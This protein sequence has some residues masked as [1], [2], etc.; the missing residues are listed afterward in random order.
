MRGA[1]SLKLEDAW[2]LY[3]RL[4]NTSSCVDGEADSRALE[5]SWRQFFTQASPAS[6]VLDLA[7]GNG[8]VAG[9]AAS[10]SHARDLKLRIVGVD[11]AQISPAAIPEATFVSGVH[12][13]TLPFANQSVDT[14]VSQFGFEYGARER[15]AKEAVRVLK[16]GGQLR[17]VVHARAGAVH[18]AISAQ[19][20]R[21]EVVLEQ[22]GVLTTLLSAAEAEADAARRVDAALA[23]CW[24]RSQS[25]LAGA[26]DQDAATYYANGLTNLWRSRHRYAPTDVQRSIDDAQQRAAGILVRQRA[27]L[28]AA[29]SRAD[30]DT[31]AG[32][33]R[34][35]GLAMNEPLPINDND[36]QQIAWLIE[37]VKRD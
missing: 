8:F 12:M 4:G 28:Q 11:A 37:G 13:E 9:V 26:P 3:W 21:L 36:N 17:F 22:D 16:P 34:A 27:L 31:I 15:C 18:Q 25:S 5:N 7:T 14:V 1:Q 6:T 33:L 29:C 24:E 19:V 35:A 10:A 30:C 2:T 20:A 32:M 23:A